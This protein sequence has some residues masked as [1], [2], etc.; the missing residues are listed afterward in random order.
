MTAANAVH[1]AV[2]ARPGLLRR[3][4]IT[5]R[6]IGI[7]ILIA[8]AAA[9]TLVPI[10]DSTSPSALVGWPSQPPSWHHLFGTDQLGRD[11]FARLFVAGR[12]DL[13]ITVFAVT[14][15]VCL[16]M[17]L[18]LVIATMPSALRTVALRLVD[19]MLAIPYLVLLLAL[20]AALG[21]GR[22]CPVSRAESAPSSSRSSWPA[23]RRT[24]GSPWRG[25]WPCANVSPWSPPASSG[26]ATRGACSATS[27][28]RCWG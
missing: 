25:P 19:A 4:R 7:G 2:L 27:H 10:I 8:A 22:W 26:T 24:R 9:F 5:E 11:I 16:G 23:G 15:S 3:P 6:G 12:V 21:T 20:A 1:P 28:P 17:L 14:I 18:G 13:G